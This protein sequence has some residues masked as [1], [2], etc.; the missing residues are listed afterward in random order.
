[1]P[2]DSTLPCHKYLKQLV[3]YFADI[4]CIMS[5]IHIVQFM[6]S[7]ISLYRKRQ[8]VIEDDSE[9]VSSMNINLFLEFDHNFKAI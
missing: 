3:T 1:M 8:F 4:S 5:C 9:E 7:A 2:R 6:A